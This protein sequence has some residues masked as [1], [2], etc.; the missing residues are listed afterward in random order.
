MVTDVEDD[1]ASAR[2]VA[3]PRHDEASCKAV[4]WCG[5]SSVASS[6]GLGKWKWWRRRLGVEQG[7]AGAARSLAAVDGE[8]QRSD[9]GGLS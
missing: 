3:R 1:D 6:G 4:W 2:L 9:Q 8:E 5:Y 7:S